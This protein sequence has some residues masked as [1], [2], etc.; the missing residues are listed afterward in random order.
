MVV[1]TDIGNVD[2]IHPRNKQDVGKRLA[3]WALA[4]NYGD[5]GLVHS[6]PIYKT[7]KVEG[8]LVRIEFDHA[9][10]LESRDGKP[11]TD[12]QIAGADGKFVAAEAQIDGR[13]LLVSSSLVPAPL[14]VRFGWHHM[15]NPNLCNG[16]GLPASPFKTDKW[17]Q[18]K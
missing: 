13:T 2:D 18:G 8:N 6:G 14:H 12:F 3:L 1:T 17:L 5:G 16:A 7:M 4:K 11:L 15:I 9:A 10:G